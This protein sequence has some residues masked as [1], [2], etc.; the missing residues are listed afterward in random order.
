MYHTLNI[1]SEM[2]YDN[3]TFRSN[4]LY[5]TFETASD[6]T[7]TNYFLNVFNSFEAG[8]PPVS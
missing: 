3:N 5:Y 2:E 8:I 4:L 7:I 6:S 1:W